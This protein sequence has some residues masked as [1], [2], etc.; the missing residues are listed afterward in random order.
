MS[1]HSDPCPDGN[2][3]MQDE[4]NPE[5]SA[6]ASQSSETKEVDPIH[7]SHF[8]FSDFH[9]KCNHP[10]RWWKY[11]NVKGEECW[12]WSPHLPLLGRKEEGKW[13]TSYASMY[14]TIL[15]KAL[16]SSI[17]NCC[18]SISGQL[19][20]VV[21]HVFSGR[22]DRSDSLKY[23]LKT[24]QWECI[25]ID[26]I[27]VEA[28]LGKSEDH[29]LLSDA[30]WNKLLARVRNREVAFIWFGTPCTTWSAARGQGS[31]PRKL[32]SVDQPFGIRNPQPP[33]TES[34]KRQLKE[35][36]LFVL[37]T[38]L[39]ARAIVAVGG[40]FGIENPKPQEGHASMFR[41]P[42]YEDL[43]RQCAVREFIFDQCRF[44]ASSTK[45]TQI[46]VH[47]PAQYHIPVHPT[48]GD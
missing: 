16:A 22:A 4:G 1:S 32:R 24:H 31:G 34:E 44:G 11:T 8:E 17:V 48:A 28:G 46:V 2:L 33:F 47:T 9:L 25:D 37:K 15:N 18:K 13:A 21:L 35:G 27:N 43:K 39:L 38:L 40:G 36:T 6:P 23:F 42:E 29:D 10:P 5:A 20:P 30:L 41:I 3:Q 45:P 7:R 26:I 19:P 14:P 12:T